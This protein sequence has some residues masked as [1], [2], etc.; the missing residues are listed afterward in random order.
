[1][2]CPAGAVAF[3]STLKVRQLSHSSRII[4]E[5]VIAIEWIVLRTDRDLEVI[6]QLRRDSKCIS[7]LQIA[8]VNLPNW[9]TTNT[10]SSHR[11]HKDIKY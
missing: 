4:I 1:M 8:G 9:N 3:L 7:R 5:P 6:I 2:V 10:S 11:A